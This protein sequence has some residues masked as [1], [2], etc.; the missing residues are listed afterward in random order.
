MNEKKTLETNLDP[1]VEKIRDQIINKIGD[2]PLDEVNK[3]IKKLLMENM[4]ETMRLAALAARVKI[5]RG[6]ISL[7]YDNKVKIN[8]KN[9]T[10]EKKFD[11]PIEEPKDNKWVRLK[12]LEACEVNGK[13]IDKDVILDVKEEDS[14]LLIEAKKAELVDDDVIEKEKPKQKIEE[15]HDK[16]EESLKSQMKQDIQTEKKE[17]TE[18]PANKNLQESSKGNEETE[19]KIEAENKNETEKKN[20]MDQHLEKDSK[21]N[22]EVGK[23]KDVEAEESQKDKVQETDK[24]QTDGIKDN[25]E[26][27]IE[28]DKEAKTEE[29]K[30]AKIE[31]NKEVIRD[32]T[33]DNTEEGKPEQKS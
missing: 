24:S 8:E 15:M 17:N 14:K 32:E 12:M 11:K 33:K 1:E 18:N 21:F 23:T 7:L 13:Q 29:V 20:L 5:I 28:E 25:K 16:K 30:E 27:K 10:Q 2:K 19:N 3:I 4:D 6:K 22:D 31:E 9:V 26:A